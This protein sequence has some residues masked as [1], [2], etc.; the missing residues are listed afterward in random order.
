MRNFDYKAGEAHT[1]AR[2]A[3]LEP[4]E[5]AIALAPV[6]R[7]A[8]DELCIPQHF[9]CYAHSRETVEA[10]IAK[11]DY[12]PRYPIFVS[13]DDSGLF[14][15]IGIVGPDNYKSS[16]DKLVY[17]RK[18][19]VEP[20]LPTSEII[21]TV[22]LALKKAREHELRETFVLL[23]EGRKT[24]PFNGHQDLPHMARHAACYIGQSPEISP[25]QII[26]RVIYDGATFE[27]SDLINMPS[28]Q[29]VLTLRPKQMSRGDFAT[30]C[31][32]GLTFLS[33]GLSPSDI[34]RGL[35][36]AC[37]KTSD[38]HV[39]THFRFDGFARF[40]RDVNIFQIAK[41][42]VKQRQCPTTYLPQ[43]QAKEFI[44]S[45]ANENYET[46]ATRIPTLS[47]TVHNRG[48]QAQLYAMNVSPP[49]IA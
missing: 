18:W 24:T 14:I 20:N 46:D 12:D 38:A 49:P 28:G 21:Q 3:L 34:L 37:L 15:Q 16:A 42:S 44:G 31:Q 30:L 2:P 36:E 7:I 9:L 8:G 13:G 29:A 11:I 6:L 22:F 43:K 35:F 17:G 1:K 25:Q 26:E 33:E 5:T 40:S 41:L 10:I 32:S 48:L 47:D 23:H 19:R 4:G 45:L 27:I 39:E